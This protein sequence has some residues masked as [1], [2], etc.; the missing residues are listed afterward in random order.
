M[1][2][3]LG[4]DNVIFIAIVVARL[5]AEQQG[6]ARRLGLGLAL[7]TRLLLLLAL[8]FLLGLQGITVFRL[9]YL[10]IPAEWLGQEEVNN[11]SLRDL[12]LIAGGL[13]L[14]AKSTYEIHEKL[15]SSRDKPAPP[16]PP[17]R[18][19]WTL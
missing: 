18:F 12:I 15:E 14:I 11:I 1:E 6:K 2:I 5:P 8:S 3:V 9:S 16:A 10:G 4:I 17:G 19:G 7:G 13:F